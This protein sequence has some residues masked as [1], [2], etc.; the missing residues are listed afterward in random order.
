MRRTISK[1]S[2]FPKCGDFPTGVNVSDRLV[3]TLTKL[4]THILAIY[5]LNP[6]APGEHDVVLLP[7]YDI[8]LYLYC[9]YAPNLP[10]SNYTN[11]IPIVPILM[12]INS[13][14]PILVEFL[15][16]RRHECMAG[17]SLDE[18]YGLYLNAY[19][20]GVQDLVFWNYIQWAWGLEM[21]KKYAKFHHDGIALLSNSDYTCTNISPCF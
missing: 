7:V 4:P 5:S 12:P 16:S 11:Y 15:T 19:T 13:M 18:L 20:L 9:S 6:E 14:V 10:P 2:P 21:C 8:V 3:K 17:L 1:L